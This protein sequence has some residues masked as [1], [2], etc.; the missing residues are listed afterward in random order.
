MAVSRT[1]NTSNFV[2]QV[3]SATDSACVDDAYVSLVLDGQVKY[4]APM[5]CGL[6]LAGFLRQIKDMAVS[7]TCNH[8]AAA[9]FDA[10]LLKSLSAMSYIAT[11]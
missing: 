10:Y 5:D 8:V 3:Y 4:G 7:R 11:R 1:C 9:A 2:G 6:E